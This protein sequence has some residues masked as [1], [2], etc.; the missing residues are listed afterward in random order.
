MR[1]LYKFALFILLLPGHIFISGEEIEVNKTKAPEKYIL[2]RIGFM[3]NFSSEG[4]ATESEVTIGVESYGN[5]FYKLCNSDGEIVVKGGML[6]KGV[7]S[8][9]VPLALITGSN[10]GVFIIYLKDGNNISKRQIVLIPDRYETIE[11]DSGSDKDE[12]VSDRYRHE[13]TVTGEDNR[14]NDYA[15]RIVMDSV[16]GDYPGLNQGIP[17]LP[18]IFLFI[19]K[20]LKTVKKKKRGPIALFSE[21]EFYIKQKKDRGKS[22]LIKLRILTSEM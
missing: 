12:S 6:L 16:N 3:Q 8:I 20:V 13:I 7:N 11:T 17:I 21:T 14:F 5:V 9:K 10:K 22:T 15:A 18:I 19:Q 4:S 1:K 2:G